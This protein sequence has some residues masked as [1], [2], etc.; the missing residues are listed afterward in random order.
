MTSCENNSYCSYYRNNNNNLYLYPILIYVII[1]N[2]HKSRINAHLKLSSGNKSNDDFL[3][4]HF[5]SSEHLGLTHLSI[6]LIDTAKGEKEL[7]KK[8]GQWT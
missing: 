8:E 4:Q 2:N 1:F 3:Y 6:L 5:H 7:R